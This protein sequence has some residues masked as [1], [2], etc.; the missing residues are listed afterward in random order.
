MTFEYAA[1]I[2][3]MTIKHANDHI[4]YSCQYHVDARFKGMKPLFHPKCLGILRY[5]ACS[6]IASAVKLH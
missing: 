2:L 4:A 5:I 6:D 1:M 3:E